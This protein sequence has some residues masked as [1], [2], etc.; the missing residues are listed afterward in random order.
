MSICSRCFGFYLF[1]ALGFILGSIWT[2]SAQATHWSPW[3][4]FGILMV[5]L[6]PLAL[7][8]ITQQRGWRQSNNALRLLTGS[9]LGGS[10]GFML[11]T[12]IW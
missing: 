5:S 12:L 3:V 9:I 4:F 6:L 8:G 1:V 7:D 10:W 11:A 2:I